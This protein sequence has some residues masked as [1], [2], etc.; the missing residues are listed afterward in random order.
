MRQPIPRRQPIFRYQ[1]VF[2]GYCYCCSNFGHK[3]ANCA[4]NFRN[5][6]QRMSSNN[7]MLQHTGRQ[8]VSKQE[9]RTNQFTPKGIT[10]VRHINPFDLLYNEPKCY[11]CHNFGHKASNY[12][13]KNYKTKPRMN[14]LDENANV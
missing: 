11:V 10:H 6:Q 3:A 12:H 8:S 9:H 1:I 4:F 7:Q 2:H 14:Y 5:I 13:M